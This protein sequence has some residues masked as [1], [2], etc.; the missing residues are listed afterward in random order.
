[1]TVI[2]TPFFALCNRLTF[3]WLTASCNTLNLASGRDWCLVGVVTVKQTLACET[4]RHLA[5]VRPGC[6]T[7]TLFVGQTDILLMLWLGDIVLWTRRNWE[8]LFFAYGPDGN[9]VGV[10]TGRHC[11]LLMD[12]TE[13]LLVLWLVDLVLCLWT[14]RKSCWCCDW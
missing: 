11:S 1:M 5:G 6:E 4:H 13:V 3:C 2:E 12:Q 8:T 9:P 7:L 14:R 10:V